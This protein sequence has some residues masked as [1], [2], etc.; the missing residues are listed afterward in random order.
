MP[1]FGRLRNASGG[2]RH[3]V[4]QQRGADLK[5]IQSTQPQPTVRGPIKFQKMQLRQP[6]GSGSRASSG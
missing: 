2:G 4:Q 1:L 6:Q 3:V 5:R